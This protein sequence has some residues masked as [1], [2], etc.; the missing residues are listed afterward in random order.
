M[1]PDKKSLRR[2]GP[3]GVGISW[4]DQARAAISRVDESLP[5]DIGLEERKEAVDAAYPFSRRC[6]YPYKVWCRIRRAY[7]EQYGYVPQRNPERGS[8]NSEE[9]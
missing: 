2:P 1:R 4:A 7:L 6:H 5:K 8:S 9:N 3:A